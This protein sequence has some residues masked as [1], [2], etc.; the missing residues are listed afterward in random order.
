MR[1]AADIGLILDFVPNHM[2]VDHADNAWWL[3][4]LEWGQKSPTRWPSTS[5]GTRCRTAVI[6]AC[7][8]RS[9]AAPTATRCKAA[10]SN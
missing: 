3:D 9:S 1:S 4:V 6:A 7:C 8:C 5:T 2:G 10:R